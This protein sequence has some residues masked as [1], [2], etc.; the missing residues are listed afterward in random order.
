MPLGTAVMVVEG[1]LRKL[2]GDAPI[3]AGVS[4]YSALRASFNLVLISGEPETERS[5]DH[6]DRFLTMNGMN[7]HQ[8]IEYTSPVM[9]EIHGSAGERVRQVSALRMKGFAVDVV[10]EPHP[11]IAAELF[12]AGYLVLHF[13][14]PQYSRPEW[15]PDHPKAGPKDWDKLQEQVAH[16]A[17]MRSQDHRT[18][19][20]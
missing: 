14:S 15:R 7:K 13:M 11:E 1:V 18:N 10:V 20:S 17:Y 19:F 9:R 2:E 4:L 12:N 3:V 5:K 16:E 6:L 8:Y